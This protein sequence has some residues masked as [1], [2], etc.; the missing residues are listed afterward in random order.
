MSFRRKETKK[1][2]R[3]RKAADGSKGSSVAPATN[4]SQAADEAGET[5][6]PTLDGIKKSRPTTQRAALKIRLKHGDVMLMEVSL[7]GSDFSP[8]QQLT[9]CVR[10]DLQGEEMQRQFEHKV[11]PEGLRFGTFEVP[12][13]VIS[14]YEADEMLL[15]QLPPLASSVPTICSRHWAPPQLGDLRRRRNQLY[16]QGKE[17]RVASLTRTRRPSSARRPIPSSSRLRSSV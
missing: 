8:V 3:A 5:A 15:V 13:E 2:S 10:A 14:G 1:R 12:P 9:Q 16:R 11:E 17:C 6:I 4:E 7:V